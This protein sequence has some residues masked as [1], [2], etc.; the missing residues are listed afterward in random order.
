MLF[1]T[2]C[3]KNLLLTL[4]KSAHRKHACVFRNF[5]LPVFSTTCGSVVGESDK[6]QEDR[7]WVFWDPLAHFKVQMA[8]I[9]VRNV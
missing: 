2:S 7:N 6:T 5:G 9:L 8:E 4:R 1:G 3:F